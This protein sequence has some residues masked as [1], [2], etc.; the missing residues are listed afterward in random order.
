MTS[1]L[2]VISLAACILDR[3]GQ[4][5]TETYKR[6]MAIQATRVQ[7]MDSSLKDAQRRIEQVEEVTRA[8]GQEE[9]MRMETVDQLRSAVAEIRGD[10]EVLQHDIGVDTE[11]AGKF[12]EDADFRLTY[13]E[14]RAAAIEKNLGLQAPPPPDRRSAS[15]IAPTS[16]G[17]GTGATTTTT[18][19][20][21]DGGEVEIKASTPEEMFKLAEGHLAENRPKVARAVLERFLAQ[22]PSD[23]R[24]P[25]VRYRLAQTW[26][27]EGE[28]QKAILGYQEVLDKHGSSAWASWAMLRQGQCFESLGQKDNAQLFY[29][30][31]IRLYP[32]SKAAKEARTLKSGGK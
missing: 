14:A 29:D 4:S 26:Y 15:V 18:Q 22:Y 5:A 6:E 1:A 28:Y 25:E 8:R 20:P 27:T 21:A 13:L 7:S 31:V 19:A 17:D 24:I 11:F 9:I 23:S 16:T 2:L 12:Q 32:K 10:L 30:D 3:T